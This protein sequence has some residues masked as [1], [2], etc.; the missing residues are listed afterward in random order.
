[1]EEREEDGE[2]GGVRDDEKGTRD[3][4][5]DVGEGEKGYASRKETSWEYRDSTEEGVHSL[6]VES[7]I[8]DINGDGELMEE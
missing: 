4:S 7:I 6:E 1:V 5:K 3:Y 8:V 2:N